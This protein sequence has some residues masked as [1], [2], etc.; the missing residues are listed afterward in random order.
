MINGAIESVFRRKDGSVQLHGWARHVSPNSAWP[1][2]RFTLMGRHDAAISVTERQIGG[3]P[4][5]GFELLLPSAEDL[6]ALYWGGLSLQVQAKGEILTLRFWDRIE[7][8]VV[9]I[10]AAHLI[11]RLHGKIDAAVLLN[12]QEAKQNRE[13]TRSF[14]E[15]VAVTTAH[16]SVL[17]QRGATTEDAEAI[18]G[19]NGFAFL[20][21]GSNSVMQQYD[22]PEDPLAVERWVTLIRARQDYCAARG[23]MF[24]Q[25]II[26]EKQS[27]IPE[28]FPARLDVPTKL[29]TGITK[30]LRSEPLFIDC[31]RSLRDLF[32]TGGLYPYR[33]LDTHLSYFG[34]EA[35]VR[36]FMHIAGLQGDIFA[37]SLR[38]EL[39]R[40][41]L[42]SKFFRGAMLEYNSAARRGLG[43][44]P[45]GARA[46][47]QRGAEGRAFWH[48]AGMAGPQPSI[49]PD[50]AHIRQLDLRARR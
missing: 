14:L 3:T 8:A 10:I 30:E 13:K 34:A 25:M 26:P 47:A 12:A 1:V 23:I 46:G 21:G 19:Q 32:I 43:I 39:R 29:L 16:E 2:E 48:G 9:E 37:T 7:E 20:L 6:A 33:K 50:C 31:Q 15:G 18:L 41:D 49:A 5:C 38:E 36:D 27:V 40:G 11:E 42:G 17:V 28:F 24:H 4:G 44:C 22:Q 45:P 35:L